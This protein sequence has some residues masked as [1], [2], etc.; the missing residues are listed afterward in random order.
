MPDSTAAYYMLTVAE[1][2]LPVTVAGS[3]S[4]GCPRRITVGPRGLMLSEILTV[5]PERGLLGA[6]D[7]FANSE[8]LDAGNS[9]A[10]RP[11]G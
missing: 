8:G 4:Y 6:S 3:D 11:G 9:R 5:E 10:V 2:I 7:G 1:G